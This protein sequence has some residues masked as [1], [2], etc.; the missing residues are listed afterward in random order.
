MH[1]SNN[2]NDNN[3]NNIKH[4]S[5]KNS[6]LNKIKSSV[7]CVVIVAVVQVWIWWIITHDKWWNDETREE[8]KGK[9]GCPEDEEYVHTH[10]HHTHTHTYIYIIY[11]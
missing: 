1:R 6:S 3:H 5:F 4:E 2:N 7:G 10:T 8:F 11:I 9:M